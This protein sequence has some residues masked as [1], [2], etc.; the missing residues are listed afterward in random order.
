MT[1]ED[2]LPLLDRAIAIASANVNQG[3][4]PYGALVV[5]DG[6][7]IAEGR[8]RVLE[9]EDV[10]A[11]AEVD[12]I[13]NACRVTGSEWLE[14]AVLVSSCDPCPLC[15]AAA[16]LA[17]IRRIAHGGPCDSGLI[18]EWVALEEVVVSRGGAGRPFQEMRAIGVDLNAGR[19]RRW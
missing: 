4:R 12:A 1:T 7:V 13:R 8:N 3:Q 10:T 18:V 9:T 19:R 5:R 2:Y 11:H 6:I 17:G 16:Q 14:G 15:R